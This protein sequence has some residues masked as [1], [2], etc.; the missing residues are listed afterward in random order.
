MKLSGAAGV[1]AVNTP[2]CLIDCPAMQSDSLNTLTAL[3]TGAIAVM[4]FAQ[5]LILLYQWKVM[6]G[7]LSEMKA[8]SE[9]TKQAADAA[10]KSADALINSERAW[11]MVNAELVIP[12][13]AGATQGNTITDTIKLFCTNAGRTPAWLTAKI[14]RLKVVDSL[15][16]LPEI[17][18]FTH[19]SPEEII[20][21][22]SEPLGVGET[23]PPVVRSLCWRASENA[24][25]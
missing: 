18:D 5:V 3:S 22:G 2:G 9:Q 14:G 21:E 19:L 16:A 15:E 17:P 24:V 10:K 7:Q 6:S 1:N 4:A 12:D 13:R 20:Y 8:T 25:F 23:K 11:V